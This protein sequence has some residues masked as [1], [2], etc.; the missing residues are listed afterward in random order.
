MLVHLENY[1]FMYYSPY[2]TFAKQRGTALTA[3]S[4]F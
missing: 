4:G 3:L 2:M 1:V